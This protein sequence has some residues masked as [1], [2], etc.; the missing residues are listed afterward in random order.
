MKQILILLITLSAMSSI[1]VMT[2]R[3]LG[4]TKH[5]VVKRKVV[6]KK[7]VHK[8]VTKKHV[9]RKN[10]NKRHN[11]RR[12]TSSWGSNSN[13]SNNSQGSTQGIGYGN[14]KVAS[15]AGPQGVQVEAQGENGTNTGSSYVAKNNEARNDFAKSKDRYG[16]SSNWGNNSRSDNNVA[17]AGKGISY[18]AG[19]SGSLL[20]Q[21]GSTGHA[22]GK[23]GSASGVSWT[24]NGN[25]AQ[26]S[27][28]DA[29]HK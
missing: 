26:N 17:T 29:R 21:K 15:Y 18:G 9:A 24:G 11:N 10:N 4:D 14:S 7:V 16:N 27:F 1:E 22:N 19:S 28:G 6:A 25:K 12:N 13:S 23:K 8:K 5:K 2:T 3:N 20:S